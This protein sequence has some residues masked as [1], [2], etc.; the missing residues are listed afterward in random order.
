MQSEHQMSADDANNGADAL[1]HAAIAAREL[2]DSTGAHAHLRAY[3]LYEAAL[4]RL[5][6]ATTNA[7]EARLAA[8]LAVQIEPSHELAQRVLL[9]VQQRFSQ[10]QVIPPSTHWPAIIAQTTGM[11]SAQARAV[12]WPFRGI[13]QP[14]GQSL[15][16]GTITRKDLIWASFDLHDDR[17][18]RAART[19]LLTELLAVE[20]AQPPRPLQVLRG[21][22]YTEQQERLELLMVGAFSMLMGML[23]LASIAVF[24][25]MRFT[26][27]PAIYGIFS[28]ALLVVMIITYYVSMRRVDSVSNYRAGR[29]GEERVVETLQ[30]LLDGQWTLIRNFVWP[31]RRGGDIDLILIGPGGIWVFEVK[32]YTGT[33]RTIGDI[34]EVRT[35][36]GWKRLSIHPGEQAR[37]NAVRLKDFLTE[38]GHPVNWVQPVVLWSYDETDSAEQRGTIT[39]DQPATPVWR[40]DEIA[41]HTDDLW[42]QGQ[43]L[44]PQNTEA[45]IATLQTTIEHVRQN[46]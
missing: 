23:I 19:L 20:P 17:L 37:R 38:Q 2:G 32:S 27:L 31:G 39:I 35:K 34:W 10:S 29:L 8:Q 40:V 18:R 46:T 41:E 22:R 3:L 4:L 9:D 12:I 43:S 42:Q 44:S 5:A 16:R 45:I 11:T 14:I 30:Y 26:V 13:H 6:R 28:L 15:D 7:D 25:L 21:S 1:I 36:R 33:V 24:L